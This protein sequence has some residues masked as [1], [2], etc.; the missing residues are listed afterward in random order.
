M[1]ALVVA[2]TSYAKEAHAE[3][4]A[5]QQVETSPKREVPNY[6]GLGMP[7][8][9]SDNF[10]VWLARILL[11]PL[12][13][14]SE[15]ILRRPIGA[16]VTGAERGNLPEKLYNFFSYGPKNS[17]GFIPVA[18]VEFGFNPSVGVYAFWNDFLAPRNTLRLHYEFWPFDWF[19]G[20]LTDR[21][22]FD[23]RSSVQLR[24]SALRRPDNVFYGVG[25]NSLQAFQSRYTSDRFD[26][27]A[28]IDSGL[29]RTSM[30]HARV[31]VRKV[32]LFAGHYGNDPSLEQEAATGAFAIPYG[33]DRGYL[34]PYTAL[35]LVLNTRKPDWER[36]SSF[37]FE[38]D[39]EQ[40]TDVEHKPASGWVRYGASATAS[41]DLNQHGRV[42][43][44]SLATLFS[45]PI[46]PSGSQVPFTE[47]V[48]LGGPTLMRGYFPGRFVGRSAAVATLAYSWPIA[49][50]FD[51]ILD[52]AVG[53]VFDEH[54]QGFRPGLFRV[55]AAL[56]LATHVADPPIEF[57]VGIGSETFDNHATIDSVC[58]TFGVPRSF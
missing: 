29:W 9:S 40:G 51:A 21:Y 20:S 5:P 55:S 28:D 2:T 3:D 37:R 45:D 27:S 47:L 44:L 49:P 57:L 39:S 52:T 42:L 26:A 54:L 32:D 1:L 35:R 17:F 15:F 33:Y 48:T 6:D 18:F 34:A 4:A 38:V 25:P 43:S 30:V 23:K 16:A 22:A 10:G 14:T 41:V 56:G 8:V 53:N 50:K 24:A 58:V 11:S 12:Y 31:G 46:G 7:N 36:G 13:F 19:G